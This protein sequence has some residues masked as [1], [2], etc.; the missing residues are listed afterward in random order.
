MYTWQITLERFVETLG[1]WCDGSFRTTD[2]AVCEH[3]NVLEYRVAVGEV[4]NVVITHIATN[5]STA[6]PPTGILR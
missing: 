1:L 3:R 4:R 6:L 5:K 2:D